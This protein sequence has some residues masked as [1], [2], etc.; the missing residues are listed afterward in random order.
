MKL[1]MHILCGVNKPRPGPAPQSV[2][3]PV[4]RGAG[5]S[6]G[7]W[8]EASHLLLALEGMC[9]CQQ[10]PPA[11][12]APREP[13]WWVGVGSRRRGR[14]QEAVT[15]WGGPGTAGEGAKVG[16]DAH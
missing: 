4:P 5:V 12:R 2:C 10:V 9:A 11:L 6:Y 13:G 8:L 7:L 15:Q 16:S 14:G 1:T 3:L